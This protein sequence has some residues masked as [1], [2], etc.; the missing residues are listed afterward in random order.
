MKKET[1][2]SGFVYCACVFN[3]P[4][5]AYGDRLRVSFLI[6]RELMLYWKII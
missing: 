6:L 5:S 1:E 2:M 3:V 4:V